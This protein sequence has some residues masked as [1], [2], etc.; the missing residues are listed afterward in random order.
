MFA[1]EENQLVQILYFYQYFGTPKGSW[2]TRVYELT[3]RWAADGHKVTVITSLYDKSDIKGKGLVSNTEIEGISVKVINLLQSN[4]HSFLRRIT[5]FGLYSII[6]I[7]YAIVLPAQIVIASSGP[8]TIG[9]PGL[10]AKWLRRRKL[11]FEVR[12]LWPE[13]AISL[14]ILKNPLLKTIS[15]WFE[16]LMYKNSS[17]VVACSKGM[18]ASIVRRFP[19]TRISV[20]P[21][22]SDVDLFRNSKLIKSFLLPKWASGKFICL[23]AGSLGQMDDVDFILETANAI[24]GSKNDVLFVIIGDGTDKK[25]LVEKKKLLNLQNV[26]FLDLI[27]KEELVGWMYYSHVNLVMFKNLSV[28]HAS[29]PNKLF[30]AFA[31]QKPVIQNTLGWMKELV[32][33]TGCGIN[34]MPGNVN[35]FIEAIKKLQSPTIANQMEVSSAQL[36]DEQFSR[37]QLA[38]KYMKALEKIW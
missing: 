18:E 35:E 17:L 28:L 8:I 3:R 37:T 26:V 13:G 24:N 2:S 23:Y 38:K 22:A 31:A 6:S 7:Y 19:K 5:T 1:K 21:N 27:P 30:D 4:K 20:I 33:Q 32:D 11:V 36:G 14:G 16:G 15:W 25:R 29:S 9:I 34:V 12:D 10:V